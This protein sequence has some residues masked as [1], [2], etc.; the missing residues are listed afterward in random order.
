MTVL[1]KWLR[2]Y[3]KCRLMM[4]RLCC[5]PSSPKVMQCPVSNPEQPDVNSA[6]AL[7]PQTLRCRPQ[8]VG[9]GPT[10]ALNVDGDIF[11]VVVR[12]DLRT[13]VPLIYLVAQAGSL[14]SWSARGHGGFSTLGGC[15]RSLCVL[16][17]SPFKACFCIWSTLP[18]AGVCD[19]ERRFAQGRT[20]R[21]AMI[22]TIR[23][24]QGSREVERRDR[25]GLG[26][27]SSRQ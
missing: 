6:R 9:D 8:V 3:G 16:H 27:P 5:R 4:T 23:P 26:E 13:D 10:P 24:P 11:P 17:A 15:R 14:F 2:R 25:T 1:S 20:G 21:T 22:Y 19:N 7:R 12:L 18:L